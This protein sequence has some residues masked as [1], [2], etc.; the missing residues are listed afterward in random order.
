MSHHE[1]GVPFR[2][3]C[4]PVKVLSKARVFVGLTNDR[5]DIDTNTADSAFGV[6]DGNDHERMDENEYE[7]TR[8]MCEDELRDAV[9]LVFVNKMDLPNAMNEEQVIEALSLKKLGQRSWRVQSC[10]A[11]SG[12]GLFEGFEDHKRL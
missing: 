8:M 1:V 2:V 11:R 6:V 3:L 4:D 7:L 5:E 10:A 9:L 12:D